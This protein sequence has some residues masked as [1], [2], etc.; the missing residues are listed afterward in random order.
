MSTRYADPFLNALMDS[1]QI[2]VRAEL[3]YN[4]AFVGTLAVNSGSVTGDRSASVRRT[5]SLTIDPA[6]LKDPAMGPRLNPF[7]SRVKIWRGVRHPGGAIDEVQVF[8]GR[9]DSVD[10]SFSGL[11]LRCADLAADVVD[12]R[13]ERE[14]GPVDL[15]GA[16]TTLVNCMKA[17]I[18]QVH[19]GI[20]YV[21]TGVTDSAV[22]GATIWATERADA[23]DSMATQLQ[24]GCEWF[25]DMTGVAQIR[26]LPAVITS[27]TP[28]VW[29]IDSGDQGVLV[30]R[31]VTQ[32]RVQVTNGVS[33]EGVPIGGV[34]PARGVW[35][36]TTDYGAAPDDPMYWGG[37]YGKVMA[38][39][40]GQQL[41]P[42]NTTQAAHDLAK[43]L[44][45]NSLAKSRSV[46]VTC[47]ANPKLQLGSVVRIF[48]AQAEID[49]MYF[50]QSLTLP[51][52][53]EQA[54]TLTCL[55]ALQLG[56]T[57]NVK[58]SD[59]DSDGWRLA[60]LRIPEGATWQP[61]R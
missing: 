48:S 32:D 30:D 34:T 54:M 18:T 60:D 6:A 1:H 15:P 16:P 56:T 47:V 53:P 23:L 19:P 10:V 25:I 43:A 45:L 17:L 13:F 50:V 49:G 7:G 38:Y 31:T 58:D 57:R 2:S 5:A 28:A 37:P 8:V 40:S 59:S 35:L 21:T 22:N 3:W 44:G 46:S 51:L 26:P 29:I 12:A 11:T 20:S 61:T 14:T 41:N 33:V 42:L 27:G 36:N 9:I 39:Y 55:G 52:V 4:G 24:P